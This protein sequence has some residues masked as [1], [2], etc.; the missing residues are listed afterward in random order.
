MYDPANLC[1]SACIQAC[2]RIHVCLSTHVEMRGKPVFYLSTTWVS[3]DQA[4]RQAPS[5]TTTYTQPCSSF[6]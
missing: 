3:A 1:V 4:Q 5:P 6:L 2:V